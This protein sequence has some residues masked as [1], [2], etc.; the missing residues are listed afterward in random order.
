MIIE[1]EI[2]E[3]WIF[4][5]I[6]IPDYTEFIS[7][8]ELHYITQ[9]KEFGNRYLRVVVNLYSQPKRIITI[10]FDRRIKR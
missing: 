1:R 2:M 9:L 8:K 6:T 4:D 7:D 3:S 10:F 5:T